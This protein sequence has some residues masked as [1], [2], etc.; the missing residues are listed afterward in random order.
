MPS[1]LNKSKL[2]SYRIKPTARESA[3]KS[4]RN[5]LKSMREDDGNDLRKKMREGPR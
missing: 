4:T 5:N 1:R 3:V 2:D